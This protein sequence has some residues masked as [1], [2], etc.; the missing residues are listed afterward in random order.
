MVTSIVGVPDASIG[1]DK[2]EY[3]IDGNSITAFAFIKPGRTYDGVT[4]PSDYIP[5]FTIDMKEKQEFNYFRYHHRTGGGNSSEFIRARGISFYGKNSEEE[6]FVPIVENIVINHIENR[7]EIKLIFDK[8]EY[9]YLHL[10]INDWNQSSGST[11]QVAEFMAGMEIPEDLLTPEPYQYTIRLDAG[12]G[13]ITSL[14]A[15]FTADEDRDLIVEFTLSRGY[16]NMVVTVDG[17]P[18]E[19]EMKESVYTIKRR[20]T[21][22]TTITIRA[23]LESFS[24]RINRGE[25]ITLITPE[26]GEVIG[27]DDFVA[28]FMLA[29][30]FANP[31]VTG[32][33]AVIEGNTVRIPSVTANVLV[34]LSASRLTGTGENPYQQMK[35]YPNPVMSGQTLTIDMSSFVTHR[36]T[37]LK[38]SGADGKILEQKTISG[39]VEKTVMNY[40]PGIYFVTIILDGED[41][42][43]KIMVQ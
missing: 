32:G 2:P 31:T 11:V 16:T 1:G 43:Y 25:G 15:K 29:A 4:G 8:V 30:N 20:I 10:V 35:I 37:L 12:E 21:N 28:T 7:D 14:P 34:T 40:T 17:D 24:V 39:G 18:Y 5:S 19:P 36:P 42:I 3:I 33:E 13:V 38:I 22:H 26:T 6:S 41:T 9:R 27:G 23:V